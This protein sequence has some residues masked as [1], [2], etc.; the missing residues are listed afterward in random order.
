MELTKK[1]K[2]SIA[3]SKYYQKNKEIVAEKRKE[4]YQKNKQSIS[5]KRKERYQQMKKEKQNA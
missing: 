1:E 2:K 4:W 5:E 3:N